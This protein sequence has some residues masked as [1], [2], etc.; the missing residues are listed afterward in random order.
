MQ[1]RHVGFTKSAPL[2]PL[3]LFPLL[4]LSLESCCSVFTR[5]IGCPDNGRIA[6]NEYLSKLQVASIH[7]SKSFS[8]VLV[9]TFSKFSQLGI[10]DAYIVV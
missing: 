2:F 4:S 5:L 7:Y 3:P 10:P 1:T 9:E 8:S 6:P